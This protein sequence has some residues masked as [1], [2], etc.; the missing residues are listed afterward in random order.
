MNTAEL[1]NLNN[2]NWLL[3]ICFLLCIFAL[4]ESDTFSLNFTSRIYKDVRYFV[5]RFIHKSTHVPLDL[6]ARGSSRLLADKPYTFPNT[7]HLDPSKNDGFHKGLA[8]KR[9]DKAIR[10]SAERHFR[11]RDAQANTHQYHHYYCN[12]EALHR[13]SDV[14]IDVESTHPQQHVESLGRTLIPNDEPFAGKSSWRL[15]NC[16]D[17]ILYEK[18]L[19]AFRKG[20]A[21]VSKHH[22]AGVTGATVAI[23]K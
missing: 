13:A 1:V 5:D 15:D 17:I 16:H 4:L 23:H 6:V 18:A 2:N 22:W 3:K 9:H 14:A 20:V 12:S 21:Y 11:G 10:F 19:F 7:C 8:T